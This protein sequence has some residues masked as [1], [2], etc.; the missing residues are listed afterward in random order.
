MTSAPTRTI[1]LAMWLALSLSAGAQTTAPITADALPAD[2][3]MPAPLTALEPVATPAPVLEGCRSLTD[4]AM[5]AD[6]KA[7]TAQSQKAELA[8][9]DQLFEEAVSRWSQALAQCEGRAK[10]RAQRNLADS[11]KT[12]ASISEQLGAGPQCA[13]AHKDATALQDIAR[14]ALSERR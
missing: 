11:Q 4:K 10:E 8:D 3:A 7:V 5:A 1:F 9:Q 14:K 6:M 2:P 12:R 13:A